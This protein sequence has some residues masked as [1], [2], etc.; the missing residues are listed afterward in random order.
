MQDSITKLAKDFF[1]SFS[2]G[3]L[4]LS[5][6]RYLAADMGQI[7]FARLG[8]EKI[9]GGLKEWRAVLAPL[10][11]IENLIALVK[12]PYGHESNAFTYSERYPEADVSDFITAVRLRMAILDILFGNGWSMYEVRVKRSSVDR[13][14]KAMT[15]ST[16]TVTVLANSEEGAI[17]SAVR[18][19]GKYN[20]KIHSAKAIGTCKNYGYSEEF[21]TKFGVLMVRAAM[22]NRVSA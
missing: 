21:I 9:Y 5:V 3:K 1:L 11:T 22:R 19:Y 13:W 6:A 10:L 17:R 7:P 15:R 2:T 12:L 16:D 8:I 18:L 20:V 4:R 14:S